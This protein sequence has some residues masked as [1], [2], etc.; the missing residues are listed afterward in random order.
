MPLS[1][2]LHIPFCRARCTY[3]DFNTYAGQEALFA[4][5]VEALCREIRAMGCFRQKPPVQTIFIG[6][7]TPTALSTAQLGTI[8][9]TCVQAFD[10][11]PQA[12][13]TSE[14][15]PGT[16]D[17]AYLRR[18]R[19]LGVNR[20][21]FGAQS[22]N[23]AELALLG[24]IHSV[25]AVSQTVENA[26]LAGFDNLGLDLIYGLPKQSPAQWQNTLAQAVALAPEHLSL[27]SLTLEEGTRLHAQVEQGLLPTPDPDQ[28]AEMYE[29]ADRMLPLYGYAQYEISNWSKPGRECRHNLTYWLNEAYLGCGPG[30]HSSEA[31]QRWWNMPALADYLSALAG[32]P[33]CAAHPAREGGE[34]IST[35]LAMAET[36]MLGLRLTREGVSTAAFE[37][38]FRQ[39]VSGVFGAEIA[40]LKALAL[41]TEEGQRLRLTAQARLLGNQV[42][43][44]FLPD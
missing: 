20:I 19:E 6:G 31:G 16:V 33:E 7:G 29:L 32:A 41:L 35:R 25:E 21:S 13:I 43:M 5:Y 15:N 30:A 18:L 28:A 38:R 22:F 44:A 12:E 23:P 39:T 40:K 26:R 24:R 36:M 17:A 14:A 8:L 2:Y 1:L 11:S 37:A 9:A 42:F 27:Y 4:P 34:I 10:V 3:C